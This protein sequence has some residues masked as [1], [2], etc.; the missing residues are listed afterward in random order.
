MK[1]DKADIKNQI[2]I[3][4]AMLNQVRF[5][6]P[7]FR[8]FIQHQTGVNRIKGNPDEINKEII[9]R[10]RIQNKKLLENIA[11]MKDQLKQIKT[12]MHNTRTQ[13]NQIVKINNSLSQGLGSCNACWGEDPDCVNCSGEGSPGWRKINKRLFN[14]YVLPAI[15]KLQEIN[16]K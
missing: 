10:L 8:L 1:V 4:Q 15:E 12:D 7:K 14:I 13:L 11:F 2:V 9:R 6:N 5:N 16:K 3:L